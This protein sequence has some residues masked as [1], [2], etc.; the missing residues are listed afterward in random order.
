MFKINVDGSRAKQ[1]RLVHSKKFRGFKF[2]KLRNS[3]SD[4]DDLRGEK[5]VIT[6][7]LIEKNEIDYTYYQLFLGFAIMFPLL[8]V[9]ITVNGLSLPLLSLGFCITSVVSFV[10][11]KWKKE[12]FIIGDIG[13]DMSEDFFNQKIKEKFNL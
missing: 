5:E 13:I 11:S 2:I 6:D 12:N 7:Y 10:I 4:K 9:A 8:V 3:F 1:L